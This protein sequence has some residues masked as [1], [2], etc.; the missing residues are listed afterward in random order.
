MNV[1]APP[2]V[3]SR[4]REALFSFLQNCK[5]EAAKDDHF[6]IA[7]ISI[8]VKHIDPLAVLESIY[9]EYELHFYMENRALDEAVAGAEAIVSASFEGP[10]RFKEVKRF[11][12][13]ILDN[14]IVTGDLNIPFSGLHFFCAFTFYNEPESVEYF[15]PATVFVPRWQ[16]SRCGGTYGAV[17]NVFV[18]EDTDLEVLT[19][20]VWKAHQRFS[21]FSYGSDKIEPESE[22][23]A[24]PEIGEV[25]GVN[26]YE[27]SV[28]T[29]LGKIAES[30]YEKIVLA[31][32]LDLNKNTPFDPLGSLNKLRSIY[33]GC[34]SFSIANG[35]R[36]SFI[37]ASPERL[38]KIEGR[39]LKMEAIAGSAPRGSS[40]SDD[41]VYAR[42]LLNSDKDLREHRLVI[43]AITR[44]LQEIGIEAQAAALPVL[45][46]LSNVQHLRSPIYSEIP[47]DRHFMDILGILH[48]TPAV[49]GTPR[50]KVI[51]EIKGL[52]AFERGLYAG[53]ARPYTVKF[54]GTA[55]LWIF[56]AFYILPQL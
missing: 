7:S 45:L 56:W 6:K 5:E 42:A 21:S 27:E 17:A 3:S 55:I 12:K 38:L 8:E 41:A 51:E 37:G 31:R 30:R 34:Y 52:E 46:Q 11:S 35:K 22:A 13:S 44:R 18:N 14:A 49:G 24:V 1:V 43:D 10:D 32:A 26:Y 4:N 19:N 29:A 28:R 47:G 54:Q 9:E 16:V 33:P 50:D 48:P 39:E 25:G 40:A 15:P 20:K 36:Q 53:V 2:P 23:D